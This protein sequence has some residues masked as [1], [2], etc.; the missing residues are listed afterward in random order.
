LESGATGTPTIFLDGL[1][2]R[3]SYE[4]AGLR[5]A[6]TATGEEKE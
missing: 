4:R 5:R 3:G 6:L 2:Y 1:R